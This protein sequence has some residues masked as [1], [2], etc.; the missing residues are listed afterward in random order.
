MSQQYR[1][2]VFL[3]GF[4]VERANELKSMLKIYH[5]SQGEVFF[6]DCLRRAHD[7][8]RVLVYES[9][10]DSDAMRVGRAIANGGAQIEVDGLTE[11]E[12]PF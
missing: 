9:N 2:K 4:D 5:N 1:V 6:K 3:V 8:E 11:E 7:G 10:S 12:E